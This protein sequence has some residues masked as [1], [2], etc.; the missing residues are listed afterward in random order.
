MILS[1]QQ[2]TIIRRICKKQEQSYLRIAAQ[3]VEE[4]KKDL[5]ADGYHASDSEIFEQIAKDLEAWDKAK[6]N[7][8]LFTTLLDENNIGMIKHHL[9]NSFDNPNA[10]P[11]WQKLNL[12][13]QVSKP[14]N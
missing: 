3:R 7:P 12:Y 4:I 5:E 14:S 1:R 10:I 11:I 9:I 8:A 2:K 6:E 13:E